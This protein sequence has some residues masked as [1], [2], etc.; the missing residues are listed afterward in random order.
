LVQGVGTVELRGAIDQAF[1]H[2]QQVQGP[3]LEVALPPGERHFV[4]IVCY[5]EQHD[6]AL[7]HWESVIV[8]VLDGTH[9]IERQMQLEQRLR[10]QQAEHAGASDQAARLSE[11]N[12]RLLSANEELTTSNAE[13]RSANEELLVANEESQAATE[14]VETLNEELQATN[15]E[16]ETLN[17][18][19]QAT[20]EELNTTNDDLESR[21]VELQ[22]LALTLEEQRR[23]SDAERSRLLAV[24]AS[25]SDAVP[26]VGHE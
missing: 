13:L 17:E 3:V 1:Q 18:E 7:S 20:V 22:D 11:A 2:N 10:D 12:Q 24:L 6:E 4:R 26:V 14:E 5:P 9:D 23:G 25:M 21:S 8:L 15:E 16:L 19:L